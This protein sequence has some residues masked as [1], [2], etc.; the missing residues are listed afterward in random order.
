MFTSLIV[1]SGLVSFCGTCVTF[2]ERT[3]GL[4][5]PI[6]NGPGVMLKLFL[7]REVVGVFVWNTL[8]CLHGL[9]KYKDL[10]LLFCWQR[11][12]SQVVQKHL[13]QFL[14][15]VHD[16]RLPRLIQNAQKIS[17]V[18]DL[19]I[20]SRSDAIRLVSIKRYASGAEIAGR[21]SGEQILV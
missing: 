13:D 10:S 12:V 17:P 19:P 3:R 7:G 2:F 15:R 20:H 18:Y 21:A 6:F 16:R 8:N 5:V 14:H 9:D 11:L 4:F 1:L